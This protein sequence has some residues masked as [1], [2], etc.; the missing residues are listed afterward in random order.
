MPHVVAG[1]VVRRRQRRPVDLS[2]RRQGELVEG[3]PGRGHHVLGKLFA[4]MAPE[5][6]LGRRLRANA[7]EVADQLLL[8]TPVRPQQ[9]GGHAHGG[10][11]QQCGLD[12]PQ[13][14]AQT[15]QFHLSVDAAEEIDLLVTGPSHE[16]TA[17]VDAPTGMEGVRD[18]FL[19]GQLRPVEIA[20]GQALVPPDEQLSG[21]ALRHQVVP[22]VDN[23]DPAVELRMADRGGGLPCDVLAFVFGAGDGRFGGPVEVHETAPG[24]VPAVDQLGRKGVRTSHDV[25][26]VGIGAGLDHGEHRRGQTRVGDTLLTHQRR[27]RVRRKPLFGRDQHQRC[28]DGERGEDLSLGHVER[29]RGQLQHPV[30]GAEV[31]RP[32]VGLDEAHQRSMLDQ[33]PFGLAGRS[34]RVEDVGQRVAG[35]PLRKRFGR[36]GLDGVPFRVQHQGRP[37]GGF[38]QPADERR[39]C[40]HHGRRRVPEHEVEARLG[41]RRVHHREGRSCLQHAEDGDEGVEVAVHDDGDHL[42]V[43]DPPRPQEPSHETSASI[44]LAVAELPAATDGRHR[45]GVAGCDPGHHDVGRIARG[46]D[47]LAATARQQGFALGLRQQRHLRHPEGGVLADGGE[48][49]HDVA[50]HCL[51]PPPVEEPG[52]V[53]DAGLKALRRLQEVHRQIEPRLGRCHRDGFDGDAG[54]LQAPP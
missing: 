53:L 6:V 46:V 51:D 38:G 27:Q 41:V 37:T 17:T 34:R 22:P 14:D 24:Q 26:Q 33:H 2:R 9:H 7:G 4:E 11:R 44:E 10:V 54:K 39:P 40:D 48:H 35:R 31:E 16:V 19:G 30:V 45:V 28:P 50:D 8:A 5:F 15:A 18:E 12:L 13:L 1:I 36:H 3:D 25:A 32:P 20:T 29:E 42:L 52:G 21:D 23:V 49:L 47:L 43:P